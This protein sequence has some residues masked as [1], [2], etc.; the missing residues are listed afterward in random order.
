VES[1]PS[2]ASLRDAIQEAE[3]RN[4]EFIRQ[5]SLAD[6]R[7]EYGALRAKEIASATSGEKLTDAEQQRSIITFFKKLYLWS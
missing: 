7:K 1:G 4:Q 5:K 2:G 6:E 3:R